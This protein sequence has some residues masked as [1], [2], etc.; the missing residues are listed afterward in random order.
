[1]AFL[2]RVSWG[3]IVVKIWR[4]LW[5]LMFKFLIKSCWIDQAY[6]LNILLLF[7]NA[8]NLSLLRS[9]LNI[10][11]CQLYKSLIIGSV[12][13]L[14]LIFLCYAWHYFYKQN[15]V[16]HRIK[17]LWWVFLYF[18]NILTTPWVCYPIQFLNVWLLTVRILFCRNLPAYSLVIY[19]C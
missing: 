14:L 13:L 8:Y 3:W 19:K 18:C 4:V 6:P 1:M 17:V 9:L 7:K 2:N 16:N 15:S 5:F 12:G 11:T 10:T